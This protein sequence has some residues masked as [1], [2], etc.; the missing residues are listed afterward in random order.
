MRPRFQISASGSLI[1]VLIAALGFAAVSARDEA[2]P[3]PE[4]IPVGDLPA[5]LSSRVA[6]AG[7]AAGFIPEIWPAWMRTDISI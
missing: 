1:V 5:S 3:T 7:L 2:P 6:A 4:T